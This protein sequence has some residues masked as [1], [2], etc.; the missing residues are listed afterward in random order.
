MIVSIIGTDG[1]FLPGSVTSLEAGGKGLQEELTKTYP[2]GLQVGA[3]GQ[4]TG[5]TLQCQKLFH[6]VLRQWMNPNDAAE[7][8]WNTF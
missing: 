5:G 6:V 4:T 3:I 1:K 7:R 8:V 2:S